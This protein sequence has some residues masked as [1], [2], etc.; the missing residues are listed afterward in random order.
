MTLFALKIT[1]AVVGLLLF[2]CVLPLLVLLKEERR[3]FKMQEAFAYRKKAMNGLIFESCWEPSDKDK[4]FV[5]SRK[6]LLEDSN[7][8]KEGVE[9]D[10]SSYLPYR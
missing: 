7:F 5:E 8:K 4:I 3:A 6:V 10:G 2:F 1:C 9:E